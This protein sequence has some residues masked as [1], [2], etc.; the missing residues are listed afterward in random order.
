MSSDSQGPDRLSPVRPQ[1]VRT[2]AAFENR[3]YRFLWSFGS[4]SYVNRWMEIT[5]MAWLVLEL[6]D[7]AFQVGIVGIFRW[8][9]MLVLGPLT[10]AISDRLNR[11]HLLMAT[12]LVNAAVSAMLTLLMLRDLV[13]VW[14]LA[15]GTALV[16][17]TWSLDFPARR[18]LM[19]DIVGTNRL[20]NAIALDSSA[21]TGSKM[22]GPF[23][24]GVLIGTAGVESA[25]ALVTVLYIIG[26]LLLSMVRVR[27]STTAARRDPILKNALQGIGYA[28]RNP[29]IARVLVITVVMN[30]LLFPYVQFVP[31]FARDVLKV[32]P[33]LMGLLMSIDGA[34][35]FVGAILVASIVLG[36]HRYGRIFIIGTLGS[37]IF[38]LLFSFSGIYG[39]SLAL[40]LLMGVSLSGFGTMQSLMLLVSSS[41]EMRGRTMGILGLAIGVQP[42]GLLLIGYL[43]DRFGAPM[44]VTISA[45][46]GLAA[47][48]LISVLSPQLWNPKRQN[49]PSVKPL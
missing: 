47:V 22:L 11:K 4:F 13:E 46:I 28:V 6:T 16:G 10:G 20:A 27:S 3:D 45:S 31:I 43:A 26:F 18:P 23:A 21:M 32:G 44:A 29:M 49:E 39:L 34:G 41:P 2:L 1:Y 42:A 17:L 9:P 37:L 25:Y 38:L 30:A 14:H 19:M 15:L 8:L 5:T 36:S 35:S 7:S 33:S 24:A 40:L 12:L 48:L